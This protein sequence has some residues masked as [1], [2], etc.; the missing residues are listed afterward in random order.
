MHIVSVVA[1]S[2]E[3]AGLVVVDSRV[4]VGRLE[5]VFFVLEQVVREFD[6]E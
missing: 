3:I 1:E 2:V 4:E 6:I 5:L